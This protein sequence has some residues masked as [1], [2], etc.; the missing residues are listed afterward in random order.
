MGFLKNLLPHD[1]SLSLKGGMIHIPPSGYSLCVTRKVS[2][3]VKM[4]LVDG[5]KIPIHH[6]DVIDEYRLTFKGGSIPLPPPRDDYFYIVS[7]RM[8]RSL[9]RSHNRNDFVVPMTGPHEEPLRV[10]GKV[11]AV[12]GLKTV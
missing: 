9:A 4:L 3:V 12:R 5:V 6:P 1:V 11:S 7:Q 8:A 2:E 10:N